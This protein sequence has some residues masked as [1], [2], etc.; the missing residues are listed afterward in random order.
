MSDCV[1]RDFCLIGVGEYVLDPV[2]TVSRS[3]EA[4]RLADREADPADA[5]AD[6]SL[7]S[8][9]ANALVLHVASP[10]AIERAVLLLLRSPQLARAV[11]SAGRQTV[12]DR[13][14]LSRQMQQY[15]ELYQSLLFPS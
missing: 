8:V 14:T 13:F 3:S 10:E 6:T 1:A 15:D 9:G 7:F 11:G 4:A 2:G 12:L 5:D